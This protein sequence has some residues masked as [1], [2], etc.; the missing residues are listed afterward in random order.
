MGGHFIATFMQDRLNIFILTI[1]GHGVISR[2]NTR[3]NSP[4]SKSSTKAER[5]WKPREYEWVIR[6]SCAGGRVAQGVEL[7]R[8][9]LR[10]L[11]LPMV[12]TGQTLAIYR[13]TL[14]AA[15][16]E[17]GRNRIDRAR[18][19]LNILCSVTTTM[20]SERP[21][22][23]TFDP[24]QVHNRI[25][26]LAPLLNSPCW[27]RASLT[28]RPP[29]Y[30][31]T[32]QIE[33]YYVSYRL[34]VGLRRALTIGRCTAWQDPFVRVE[35]HKVTK[36]TPL[37]EMWAKLNAGRYDDEIYRHTLREFSGV[38]NGAAHEPIALDE[39]WVKSHAH[40]TRSQPSMTRKTALS[41]A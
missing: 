17:V 28:A 37:R 1:V 10:D 24:N 6:S 40:Y 15:P 11:R 3:K 38:C 7:R 34:C 8:G 19:G 39:D 12:P 25:V 30:F 14:G 41:S 20:K 16:I 31:P 33:K 18:E 5:P 13:G 29:T 2:S 27:L 36:K 26:K 23:G 35:A 32:L 4:T 21:E 9:Y 22:D